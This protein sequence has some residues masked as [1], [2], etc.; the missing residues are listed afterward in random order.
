MANEPTGSG[1]EY[2][3]TGVITGVR[4]KLMAKLCTMIQIITLLLLQVTGN[5]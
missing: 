5:L 2:R 4:V 1:L 3:I